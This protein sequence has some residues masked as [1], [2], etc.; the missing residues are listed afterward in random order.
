MF[1]KLLIVA[2]PLLAAYLVTTIWHRRLKQYA[3]FPQ[4]KPSLIWGHMKA[5]HEFR[6]R[7]PPDRHVGKHPHSQTTPRY[8]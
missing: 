4:L 1:A 8:A 5:L 6:Q 3:H 7:G 2:L